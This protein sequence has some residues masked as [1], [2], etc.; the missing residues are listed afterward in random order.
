MLK[1]H[2]KFLLIDK[3]GKHKL[4][5]EVNWQPENE[6]INDCK[7][8]KFTCPSGEEVY[9]DKKHLLEMLFVMGSQEEK[10]KMIPQTLT[11]T[12]WYETVLSVT[13]KK[14]IHKGEEIVFPIKLSL[15]S[16]EE[17]IIGEIRE[18]KTRTNIP[19]I[20]K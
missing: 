6:D 12:R 7:I 4:V 13:A 3:N 15:P 10:A 9:V 8:V 5:A 1:S 14:D 19:I 2:E 11:R 18:S 17:E 16:T 20:G